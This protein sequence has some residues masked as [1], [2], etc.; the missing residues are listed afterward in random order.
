MPEFIPEPIPGY[1][2]LLDVSPARSRLVAILREF[3]HLLVAFS[4]G[5]DSTYLLAEAVSILGNRRVAAMIAVSPSLPQHELIEAKASALRIGATLH[6]RETRELLDP[7]FYENPPNRCWHCKSA[8]FRECRQLLASFPEPDRWSIA[9][10]A[11]LDDLGED[12]PGMQA[13]QSMG[14][15]APLL[16]AKMGKEEIRAVSRELGL[17]TADK[18]PL[19]CLSSRFPTF[20]LITEERLRRVEAAEG[21]L[22]AEGFRL[23][24]VRYSGN[25][26]RIEVGADE[27]ERLREPGLLGFISRRIEDV[28]FD[29]V[30]VDPRGYRPGGANQQDGPGM[31]ERL[32]PPA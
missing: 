21:V 13:A 26:A 14:V 18:P 25:V 6:Q 29:R 32:P 15:R 9:Y 12:R 24:R 22:R 7:Q 11:N 3:D 23:F 5:V 1:V 17:P 27:L 20:T 19:A 16:E 10:G 28:G 8:L 4:G 31:G 2:N 30:E